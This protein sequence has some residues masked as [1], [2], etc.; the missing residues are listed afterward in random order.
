MQTCAIRDSDG[1]V[2]CWGGNANGQLGDGTM[3]DSATPTR[4]VGVT[5][6]VEVAAGADTTCARSSD[7]SVGC[8]GDDSAGQLGDGATHTTCTG[9]TDCSLVPIPVPGL[10][11]AAT[12]RVGNLVTA[13]ISTA[14][15]AFFWGEN[16]LGQ[17]G[18]G[19][20][21][22]RPAPTEVSLDGVVQ[23]VPD[24]AEYSCALRNDGDVYCW[25]SGDQGILGD[26]SGVPICRTV[27]T[28]DYHCS[29]TPMRLA[30]VPSALELVAGGAHACVRRMDG[31]V[32]CWGSGFL[33][34]GTEHTP[35]DSPG[36]VVGLTDAAELAAGNLHT[37]ARRSDG[38]VVCWGGG[39]MGQLGNGTRPDFALTPVPVSGL[40]DVVEIAA[41]WDRT[42][43]R[44]ADRSIACWGVMLDGVHPTPVD[45][46]L[47]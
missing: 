22:S 38:T 33:G 47:P 26:P 15:T 41:G 43:A 44:R 29:K 30:F 7:G 31:T 46:T 28:T 23:I 2:W 16:E 4:V 39:A 1:T 36:T 34:D 37:C 12:L 10:P 40:S 8:W 3:I 20:L 25:G 32:S 27:G 18:D 9:M 24:P 45:V 5:G 42:C 17:L 19:T 6:A 21:T 35:V 13:T 11:S 14:Q